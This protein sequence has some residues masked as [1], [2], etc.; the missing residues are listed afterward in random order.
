[1]LQVNRLGVGDSVGICTNEDGDLVVASNSEEVRQ[2]TVRPTYGAAAVQHMPPPPPGKAESFINGNPSSHTPFLSLLPLPSL[3]LPVFENRAL[4]S[5]M[6]QF[7]TWSKCLHDI[8]SAC[9]NTQEWACWL[10][11]QILSQ[12]LLQGL[13]HH[14]S[15]KANFVFS[16]YHHHL[17]LLFFFFVKFR[18]CSSLT[19]RALTGTA[20]PKMWLVACRCSRPVWA[21]PLLHQVCRPQRLLLRPTSHERG[22]W[23]SQAEAG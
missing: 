5:K 16:Y 21:Q 4:P 20:M 14:S 22:Q 11:G 19:K 2:A 18:P 23:G 6:F 9:S 17:Y 13:L 8:P 3:V 1:M 10:L 7:Y 12:M 15:I